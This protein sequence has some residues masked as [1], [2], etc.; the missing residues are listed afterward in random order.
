MVGGFGKAQLA[1]P[2]DGGDSSTRRVWL[3]DVGA[4]TVTFISPN[5]SY[6]CIYR[7]VKA[8]YVAR[9]RRDAAYST[10]RCRKDIAQGGDQR[11]HI[12]QQADSSKSIV[13]FVPDT[14]YR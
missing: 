7:W 5:R 2:V 6:V 4:R 11:E 12:Q 8:V 1:E 13:S 10:R 9:T 3:V 14:D